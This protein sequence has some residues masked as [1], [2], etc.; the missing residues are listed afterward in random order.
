MSG[1]NLDEVEEEGGAVNRKNAELILK[2]I[3]LYPFD[4]FKV[5]V[6]DLIHIML[7]QGLLEF[8][9]F[10]ENCAKTPA[11]LAGYDR[12]KIDVVEECGAF[13]FTS[14]EVW[15][16]DEAAFKAQFNQG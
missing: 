16:H 1:T 13:V 7:D 3:G 6:K 9:N 14:T 12:A 4:L 11:F 8:V 10:M 5:R 15:S 2:H